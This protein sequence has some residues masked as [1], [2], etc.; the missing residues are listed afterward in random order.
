MVQ[1]YFLFFHRK[2]FPVTD[3][4]LGLEINFYNFHHN[5]PQYSF[6]SDIWLFTFNKQFPLVLL[7][8]LDNEKY[9]LNNIAQGDRQS[10]QVIFNHYWDQVYS[11]AFTFTKSAE[12]SKDLA[13]DIF[14]QIWIKKEALKEV[15]R[16]EAYLYVTAR[17]LII[18]RLRKKVYVHENED[19]LKNYFGESEHQPHQQLEFKELEQSIHQAISRLP[20]QQQTAFKLSRFQGLSHD[21]IAKQ[22]G[23]SKQSVKSYIVR[24]IV[25]LRQFIK[26]QPGNAILY[27]FVLFFFQ[28]KI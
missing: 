23:I 2:L 13:Q 21:E 11:T 25:Q 22:M 5:Y 12:I 4:Y 26:E 15:S 18:D 27:L 17:N 8:A 28:K 16:F 1:N 20:A 7:K 3:C 19:Y 9:L 6:I 10:Y 14:V 24:A